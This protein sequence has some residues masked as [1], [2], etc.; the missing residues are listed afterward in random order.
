MS[1]KDHNQIMHKLGVIEG[2]LKG[3]DEGVKRINGTNDR[4]QKEINKLNN[5]RSNING[6]ILTISALSGAVVAIITAVVVKWVL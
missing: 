6:R 1:D 3:I 2:R 5:W 4:Q